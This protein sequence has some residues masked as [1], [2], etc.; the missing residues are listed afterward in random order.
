MRGYE[1]EPGRYIAITDD[2]LEAI[3]PKLSQEIDLRRFVPLSDIDPM[4]FERGY[5]LVPG[6]RAGKAYR[7]L[8]H[9]MEERQRAGIATFVMRE[10]EYLVA[11]TARDG[12]LRAESLR[13]ADEL[14]DA[15]AVGLTQPT[16]ADEKRVRAFERQIDTLRAKNSM[17]TNCRTITRWRSFV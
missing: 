17:G 4:Y 2:E 3:A 13:F 15:K 16:K 6:K 10:K 11:I 9:I 5:F 7:L 1:V 8:A 12:L 14:R